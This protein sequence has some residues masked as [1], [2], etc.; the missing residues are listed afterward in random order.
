VLAH[1]T[2]ETGESREGLRVG[3]FALAEKGAYAFGPLLT[4]LLL[5]AMGFVSSTTGELAQPP[6]AV[7]AAR[8]AMSVIPAV[9][10][11]IAIFAISLYRLPAE[12]T[13]D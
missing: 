13:R 1:S 4:G 5:G 11:A 6:S 7:L 2:R 3:V 10:G 9:I 8:L 12:V